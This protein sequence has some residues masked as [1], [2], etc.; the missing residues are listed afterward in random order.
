MARQ[1]VYE[2]TLDLRLKQRYA[3]QGLDRMAQSP[4]RNQDLPVV[5]VKINDT[6]PE[7]WVDSGAGVNVIGETTWQKHLQTM[8]LEH[9]T[10][11]LVPDGVAP[12][13][14]V[15]GKFSATVCALY[16]VIEAT[17][18][19]VKGTHRSLLSYKTASDLKLITI[20]QLITEHSS[21]DAKKEFPK[22][23]GKVGRFKNF[24]VKLNISQDVQPVVRQHRRIPF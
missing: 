6:P 14:P 24:H 21:V 9:T 17:A 10:T 2:T 4:S 20:L 18:Y 19:V 5:T 12:E 13:I 16:Q 22:L 15:M 8:Q 23:F 1:P 3:D 11:K 7:F